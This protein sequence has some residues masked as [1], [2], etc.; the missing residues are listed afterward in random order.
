MLKLTVNV[1]PR[2]R[3]GVEEGFSSLF[4]AGRAAK[5][6]LFDAGRAAK[7]TLVDA[8][9][10]AKAALA[11][12]AAAFLCSAAFVGAGAADKIAEASKVKP[13]AVP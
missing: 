3:Q 2:A 5:A 6:A 7:A 4:D 11:V 9:R 1:P 10:A 13:N 12:A 8:G